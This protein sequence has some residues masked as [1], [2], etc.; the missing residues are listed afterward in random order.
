MVKN[1]CF[2]LQIFSILCEIKPQ[3]AKCEIKRNIKELLS[4]PTSKIVNAIEIGKK[5]DS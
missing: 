2:S 4:S 3:Y 1:H 5:Y